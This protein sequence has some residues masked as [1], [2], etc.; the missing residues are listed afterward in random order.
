MNFQDI[1]KNVRQIDKKILKIVKNGL[2]F[3]T[4]FCL[5]AI[6]VLVL[7]ITLGN[8]YTYYIGMSLL[9]SGLFYLV[10]FIICGIAFNKIIG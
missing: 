8:P 9:K 5:I 6:Y 3:S 7:Y 10:S 4:V 1:I 2:K